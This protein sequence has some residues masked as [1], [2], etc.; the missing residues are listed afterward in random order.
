MVKE[1]EKEGKKYYRCEACGF[2]YKTREL[3]QKCQDW[4]ERTK[5]CNIEITKHAVKFD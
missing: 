1:V 2:F 5:S 3:A 4:C